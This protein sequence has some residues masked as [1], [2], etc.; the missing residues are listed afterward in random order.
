MPSRRSVR[1]LDRIDPEALKA[2]Q[3][4]L[5]RRY[6]DEEIVDQLQAAAERL[7]RSPTMREFASDPDTT[8]HPQ[9]VISH[10]GSWNA[11]KRAAGLVPRRFTTRE[12]LVRLLARA[13]RAARPHADGPRPGRE[14][15][16]R[17]VE[18]AL[19]AHVRLADDGPARGRV[20]RARRRGAA[21]ARAGPGRR[22]WRNGWG[23]CRSSTT[24]RPRAARTAR[25]SASGRST[26]CSRAAAAPGRRS[27]TSSRSGWSRK[28]SAWRRTD[29][30]RRHDSQGLSPG[31]SGLTH[32]VTIDRNA[33][34]TPV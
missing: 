15:W 11:A 28:A 27:S 25:S 30:W 6:S 17:P 4:G 34:A 13:G 2:F 16:A 8:V 14:P 19:L 20:R 31:V 23:G 33:R 22:R 24:G 3:A 7:G 12:D 5:R 26:A 32:T 29:G 21:R 18:V 9:T 1:A 10:F